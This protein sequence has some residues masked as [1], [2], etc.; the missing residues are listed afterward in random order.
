M[1]IHI[2]DTGNQSISGVKTFADNAIF[3]VSLSS[4]LIETPSGTSRGWNSNYTTT[5]SNSANWESTFT[6]VQT[7]SAN[8]IL[9]GGNTVTAPLSVG[10]NTDQ[11]LVFETNSSSR[12]IITSGGEISIG[13]RTPLNVGGSSVVSISGAASNGTLLLVRGSATAGGSIFQAVNNSNIGLRISELGAMFGPSV[14]SFASG[15][16]A[17]ISLGGVNNTNT[18]STSNSGSHTAIDYVFR[19]GQADRT[20]GRL[21]QVQNFTVPVFTITASSSSSRV[22]IGTATPNESLTVVGKISATSDI[23][24]SGNYIGGN[25]ANW[26]TAYSLVSSNNLVYTTGDQTIAGNKTFSNNVTHNGL[27]KATAQNTLTGTVATDVIT[28]NLLD[29]SFGEK[30]QCFYISVAA[31]GGNQTTTQFANQGSLSFGSAPIAGSS[32]FATLATPNILVHGNALNS[33]TGGQG[34][35]IDWRTNHAAIFPIT[36]PFLSSTARD[37]EIR[38][39]LGACTLLNT[40][41]RLGTL[42]TNNGYG[43]VI[44][45]HPVNNTYI[46]RL[47]C[48]TTTSGSAGITSATNT[49]PIVITQNFHGLSA[50]DTVEIIGVGG[51]TAANGVFTVQNPTRDTFELVGTTGNGAYTSG[52]VAQRITSS[53]IE[54][55]PQTSYIFCIKWTFATRTISLHLNNLD[56]PAVLSIDRVGIAFSVSTQQTAGLRIGFTS[57]T[58]TTPFNCFTYGTPQIFKI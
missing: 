19:A 51:N 23:S 20:A 57:I 52:G 47:A 33:T 42:A 8:Y 13:T 36:T 25:T 15:G 28:K 16:G 6:N 41:T 3:E 48:R 10:T 26:Q 2:T 43:I 29:T 53:S 44:S 40:N 24:T 45:K 31:I 34:N 4:A 54:I 56:Q 5:N 37:I 32:T 7:N 30:G 35:M 11:S 12:M 58:D 9:N 1:P 55:N 21:F 50:A 18:F 14:A 46:V 17:T 49:T 38:I 39:Y 22:G 27:L